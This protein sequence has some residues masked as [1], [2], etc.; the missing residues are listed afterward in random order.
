[1]YGIRLDATANYWKIQNNILSGVTTNHIRAYQASSNTVLYSH[2][3]YYPTKDFYDAGTTR[4]FAAWQALD[5]NHDANSMLNS[6]PL[7]TGYT[8]PSNSP[9][10]DTGTNTSVTTDVRGLPRPFNLY[11]IGCYEIGGGF[12]GSTTGGLH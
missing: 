9:C 12:M 6:D 2:N 11:E 4:T 7:L 1:L 10:K 5:A 8:I 3:C